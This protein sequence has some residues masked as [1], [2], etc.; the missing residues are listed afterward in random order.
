MRKRVV[1][2]IQKEFYDFKH[3][4]IRK[5]SKTEIFENCT[6]ICFYSCVKEYFE[7]NKDIPFPYMQT[8]YHLNGFLD[9]A[10]RYFLKYEELRYDTW[11]ALDDLM[12]CMADHEWALIITREERKHMM[13]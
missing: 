12:K 2:K 11:E 3:K 6:K 1:R 8:A 9:L 5:G 4:L 7:L 10:W 13:S